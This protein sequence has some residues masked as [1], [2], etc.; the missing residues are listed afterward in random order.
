MSATSKEVLAETH[1]AKAKIPTGVELLP[2]DEAF[3][4]N[5]YPALELLRSTEPVHRDNALGRWFITKFEDAR[6]ILRNKDLST[7]AAAMADPESYMGR[8][9]TNVKDNG[10]E[11]VMEGMLWKDDP[12]HRR[13]RSLVSKPFSAKAIEELRPM[14][15]ANVA[16]LLDTITDARFDLVKTLSD[17][18][19]VLIIAEML[20][21]ERELRTEFKQWSAD[22]V[23]GFFN[24]LK[25]AEQ[26]ERGA[27][28]FHA[29]V[30]YF[31]RAIQERRQQPGG[32]D[33]ISVILAESQADE[34]ITESEILAQ[35]LLILVAGNI[36]TTDLI[37]NSIK[38]LLQHP[39][40]LA[41]LRDE[42]ELITNAIE[43][44]LRYDS[45]VTQA[46]RT[47]AKDGVIAGCPIH[48]GQT[49]TVS[50]AAANR[51]PRANPDPD[52]FDIR[53]KNIQ[54][55]SFGAADTC[56][57]E[58]TWRA[59]RRRKQVLGI[60]QRFSKLSLV[61]EKFEYRPVPSVRGLKDLWVRRE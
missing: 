3:R 21:I 36:T 59:S 53:R 8:L 32:T 52:R 38:A 7:D 56:A 57:W 6:E 9:A 28:A 26:N 12:D 34:R 35:C 15:K 61:D 5:P 33:V 27:R 11:L 42:P 48:K 22:L 41:A 31:T 2:L 46:Q 17:P 40:Q 58:P 16:A 51:D 20:G 54:H 1:D 10:I 25:L 50:V 19:P 13:L 23:A 4:N 18:L 55:Q 44:V 49:I 43:E 14:I 39:A 29:L 45:S 24:P 37:G 47:V 30:K 60:L